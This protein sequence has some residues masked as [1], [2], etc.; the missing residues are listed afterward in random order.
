[1]KKTILLLTVILLLTSCNSR[2]K[3]SFLLKKTISVEG[4]LDGKFSNIMDYNNV[5][6]I[7]DTIVLKTINNKTSL[8]GRYKGKLP[9]IFGK[10]GNDATEYDIAKRIK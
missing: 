4:I 8:Y 9:T 5:V 10:E 7:G 2:S 1:M 6:N 3:K